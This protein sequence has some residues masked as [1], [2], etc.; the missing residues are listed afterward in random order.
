[1]VQGAVA[2][3]FTGE[4]DEFGQVL[5]PEEGASENGFIKAEATAFGQ[6]VER[7]LLVKGLIMDELAEMK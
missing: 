3:I 7:S 4:E 1:M 5:Q 2:T 6:W